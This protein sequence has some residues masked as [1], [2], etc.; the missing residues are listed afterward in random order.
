L[1]ET[2]PAIIEANEITII[3]DSWF[4]TMAQRKRALRTQVGNNASFVAVFGSAMTEPG[5]P[6]WIRAYEVGAALAKAGAVTMNGGYGGTMEAVSA[7]A[8]SLGGKVVGITCEDLPEKSS[9]PY[10]TDNWVAD[11]WDQR[12]LALVWLADGYVVC[13]GSSGTLVELSMV[14]ETQL[15]GFLPIRPVVGLGMFWKSV[16]QRIIDTKK[17]ITYSSNPAT[18]AQLAAGLKKART[19]KLSEPQKQPKVE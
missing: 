17:I 9:N 11:R 6:D 2:L 13:P 7:G 18:V 5:S 15:K 4:M 16:T 12:L 10:I 14:I 1:T 8:V 3:N 19:T